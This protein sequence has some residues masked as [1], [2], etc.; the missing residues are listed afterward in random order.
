MSLSIIFADLDRLHAPR[1]GPGLCAAA[2]VAMAAWLGWG[3]GLARAQ[4]PESRIERPAEPTPTL[5]LDALERGMR[6]YGMTVFEGT[7]PEPFEF[8]VVSVVRDSSPRRSVI[9]VRCVDPR[10]VESGPVQGMSGSPMFVW[11]AGEAQ[12]PGEGGRL[13]GAFAFGY[14]FSKACYVGVQPIAYMRELAEREVNPGA[15]AHGHGIGLSEARRQLESMAGR[16]ALHAATRDRLGWSLRLLDAMGVTAASRMARSSARPAATHAGHE[17]EAMRLALPVGSREAVDLAAPLLERFG[18]TVVPGGG[19]SAGAGLMQAEAAGGNAGIT[20]TLRPGAA[21]SVPIVMGDW[22]ASAAGTVTDILP[23]GTVLGFGHPMFGGG[24]T[25]VPMATGE[26]HFVMPRLD[27]SF[28]QSSSLEVVGT[29]RRDAAAG[30]AGSEGLD[31]ESAEVRADVALPGLAPASYAYRVVEVPGMT[32]TFAA[33]AV[34]QSITAV[35]GLPPQNTARLR[36]EIAFEGGH[37]LELDTLTPMADPMALAVDLLAPTALM[38]MNSFEPTRLTSMR[39]EVEVAPRVRQATVVDATLGA[40]EVAPGDT[41]E[42]TVRLQPFGEPAT[43]RTLSIRVPADT[44]EGDYTLAVGGAQTF[45]SMTLGSRPHLLQPQSLDDYRDTIQRIFNVQGDAL[46]AVLQLQRQAVAVGR[47]ELS[48]LPSSRA[49]ILATPT[50]TRA[51]RFLETVHA[52]ED[53]PYVTLGGRML[54]LSVREPLGRA[55]PGGDD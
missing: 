13:I 5:G 3:G 31:F 25:A 50:S 16:T 7:D 47:A 29:L 17:V 4:G 30:V 37:A 43:Q 41:A 9:W 24:D 55:Q 52:T 26:I 28:K 21:L 40:V 46:Y 32:P 15:A 12:E 51:S 53:V 6:G 36:A 10:L 39:V 22:D 44:P 19:G 33:L 54:M 23:D 38:T 1:L 8:E 2:V 45:L 35:Q 27:I 48:G 14:P 34:L 42:V 20:T 11:E 18:L 49:A